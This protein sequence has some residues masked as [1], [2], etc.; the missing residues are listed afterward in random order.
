LNIHASI[1]KVDVDS[2]LYP[3]Y[4]SDLEFG[5]PTSLALTLSQLFYDFRN[6]LTALGVD[7]LSFIDEEFEQPKVPLHGAGWT[8]ESLRDVFDLQYIP[9]E[10]VDSCPE[11]LLHYHVWEYRDEDISWELQE[12]SW[13]NLLK[14]IRERKENG[15]S[16]E[17]ILQIREQE[18]VESG[19]PARGICE[20]EFCNIGKANCAKLQTFRRMKS[21]EEREEE[22]EEEEEDSPFL[23]SI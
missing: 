21:E 8:K 17:E 19:E 2:K 16:I 4:K 15:M 20:S 6:V 12:K 13:L 3:G 7:I 22:E 9:L 23:L 18:I 5:T 11:C 10:G 14:R 1:A